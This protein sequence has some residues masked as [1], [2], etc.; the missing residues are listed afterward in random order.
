MDLLSLGKTIA[1]AGLPLLGTAIGGPG[2]A[3]LASLAAKAL[4]LDANAEPAAVAAAVS[5]NP[6]AV[7]KLNDLQSKHEEVMVQAAYAAQAAADNAAVAQ[8][9]TYNKTLQT[10]AMGGDW[11]QRNHHAV[12]SLAVVGMT[13]GIYFV[14]PLAGIPVPTVPEFAFMMLGSILGV[15]AWQRGKANV[16]TAGAANA[17]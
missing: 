16:I 3:V 5:S 1:A 6:D 12:E 8:V 4:G 7:L 10:E 2:G 15:T 9:E 11:L 17:R 13:I 14:L